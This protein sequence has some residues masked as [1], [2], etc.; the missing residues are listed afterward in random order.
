MVG[1]YVVLVVLLYWLRIVDIKLVLIVRFC[2]FMIVF[3]D[4][5]VLV[6]VLLGNK[7]WVLC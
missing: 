4:E 1:Y 6:V 3:F 2:I 5:L 7:I